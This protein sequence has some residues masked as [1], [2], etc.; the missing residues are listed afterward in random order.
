M[1]A[2]ADVNSEGDL[3]CA[4]APSLASVLTDRTGLLVAPVY[5]L[6][7]PVSAGLSELHGPLPSGAFAGQ[8]AGADAGPAV[9]E[10]ADAVARRL[11]DLG[12]LCRAG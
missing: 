1:D 9:R 12:L 3:S 7:D 11:L 2:P 8:L 6:A 4:E 5:E 10:A